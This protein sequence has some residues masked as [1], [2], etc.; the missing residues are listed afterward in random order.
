MVFQGCCVAH[1]WKSSLLRRVEVQIRQ[2]GT[3]WDRLPPMPRSSEAFRIHCNDRPSATF[4]S[5]RVR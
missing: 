5:G 1:A 2:P 3:T 4:E